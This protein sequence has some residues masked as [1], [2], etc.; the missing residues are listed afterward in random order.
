MVKILSE[1][2]AA[3][4]LRNEVIEAADY[5]I[6]EY[7]IEQILSNIIDVITIIIIG[8]VIGNVQY[9][10]TF[11]IAFMAL[12][13]YAGGYHASTPLRCYLLTVT[14]IT[15][16]L[17]IMKYIEVCYNAGLIMLTVSGLI[18]ILL[19]PVESV[20]KPLDRIERTVYRR[21]ALIIWCVET[22]IAVICTVF[23]L[24]DIATC[25][26]MAQVVLGISQITGLLFHGTA[27]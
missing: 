23:H 3:R 19:S 15:I 5:E 6:Y 20:N 13:E 11:L 8:V 14:V 12:R 21:K 10:I 27:I 17:L 26:I 16:V 2:I 1:K 18:I 9:G 22:L 7:G 24:G 25:I 4:L